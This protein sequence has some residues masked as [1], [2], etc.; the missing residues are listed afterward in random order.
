[1]NNE[2]K[3]SFRTKSFR[4]GG[5]NLALILAVTAI[6]IVINIVVNS[7]PEI[8]TKMDT[9]STSLYSITPETEDIVKA[10]SEDVTVYLIASAGSEDSTI[11]ELLGRYTSLNSHIRVKYVD[12]ASNPNFV[13]KYTS[14]NL[15]ESSLIF[16]SARRTTTVDNI[17]IYPV[18][19]T[20]EEYYNYYYYGVM[21]KGTTSFAG[22]GEITSALQY[23]TSDSIPVVYVLGG[24]GETDLDDT[25]RGYISNDNIVLESLSLL[26]EDKVPDDAQAIIV[27]N[28]TSDINNDELQMLRAYLDNGGKIIITTGYDTPALTNLFTITS[29]YGANRAEGLIVEGNRNYYTGGYPYFILPKIASTGISSLISNSNM[30]VLMPYAH[31]ITKNTEAVGDDLTYTA[32]FSSSA[33]AYLKD[34]SG[35][36]VSLEH[37]D[38]DPTGSVDLGVMLTDNGTGGTVIWFSSPHL[39]DSSID[40][41]ISNGNSTYFLATLSYICEKPASVTIASKSMQ[42]QALVIDDAASNIWGALMT[43]I[44]PLGVLI[45]GGIYWYKRRKA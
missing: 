11:V 22:E 2:I 31:G 43:I 13:S 30:Y 23:V 37:L 36:N 14:E 38:T 20:E 9:S 33:A 18:E 28:P 45:G 24:H 34:V 10:I 44:I 5:Y 6:I 3:S 27:N 40:G 42:I 25:Y 16:E 32:L 7:L 1:M 26:V 4:A 21:P 41:Y 17:D 15:S 19:Y 35:E 29:E 39:L 12:P 8:F